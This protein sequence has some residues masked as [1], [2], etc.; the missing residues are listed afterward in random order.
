MTDEQMELTI[1]SVEA[2]NNAI[3][4]ALINPQTGIVEDCRYVEEVRDMGARIHFCT[5]DVYGDGFCQGKCNKY[6]R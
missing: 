5:L 6:E 2:M 1:K 3:L 4:D